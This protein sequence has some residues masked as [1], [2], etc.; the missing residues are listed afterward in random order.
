MAARPITLNSG[1]RRTRDAMREAHDD[2]RHGGGNAPHDVL[3]HWATCCADCNARHRY[4]VQDV[5]S[6]GRFLSDLAAGGGTNM[7]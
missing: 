2:G 3:A 5:L 4:E 1:D 6:V 7:V